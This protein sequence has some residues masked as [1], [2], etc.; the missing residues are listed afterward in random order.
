MPDFA[1]PLAFL[2]LPLPLLAM[3]LLPG[4][5]AVT[6]ALLLPASIRRTLPDGAENGVRVRVRRAVPAL[7]WIALVTALAGPQSVETVEALPVSGRDLV[8]ALD[9]SGSMEREDF[10]LDG[11][12]VSRLE[13]VKSVAKRFVAERAGDRVGLV[14]FAENAYVAAPLTFDVAA[15]ARTIDEA[16]IGLSGRSTAIAGGLGVA[17]KRLDG[18]TARS[19]VVILLSDGADTSGTVIPEDVAHLARQIGV[20]VYTIALGPAD[21]ESQP[22]TRD[23]VDTK[24]LRAIAETS[25]GESFRVR[26]TADLEAVTAAIDRLQASGLAKPPASVR[27]AFWIYPAMVAFACALFLVVS[28]RAL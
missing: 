16:T 25:G 24:T 11:A 8:I 21:L 17:L 20:T 23:A 10:T 15:V 2:L 13:A 1:L 5:E 22:E 4:R 14:I 19:R 3:R 27:Q 7:L 12:T 9:L 6:G 18:S 28:R 26:D